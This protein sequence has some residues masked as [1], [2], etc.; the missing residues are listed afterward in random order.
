MAWYKQ[1]YVTW[2]S[3]CPCRWLKLNDDTISHTLGYERLK[4]ITMCDFGFL[5][6][7]EKMKTASSI[8]PVKCFIAMHYPARKQS[9][10]VK[11]MP[12]WNSDNSNK[13][14]GVKCREM[15]WNKNKKWL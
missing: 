4:R 10:D 7:S 11:Y 6:P 5:M 14:Q 9:R 1:P 13:W 3:T 15:S 12:L 2:H 8:L